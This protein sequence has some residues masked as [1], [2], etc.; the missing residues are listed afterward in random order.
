V[1]LSD[2]HPVVDIKASDIAAD[3]L[4][5]LE[6]VLSVINSFGASLAQAGRTCGLCNAGTNR[7]TVRGPVWAICPYCRLT[8]STGANG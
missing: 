7:R 6:L 2:A 3:S 5:L 8:V 4:Q 1:T